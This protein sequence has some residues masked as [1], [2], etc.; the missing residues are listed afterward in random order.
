MLQ[1]FC[2]DHFFDLIAPVFSFFKS[3]VKDI[4]YNKM[5]GLLLMCVIVKS[6]CAYSDDNCFAM[7]NGLE[8]HIRFFFAE[9]PLKSQLSGLFE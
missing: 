5:Y 7:K 9:K 8:Q 3:C 1:I 4:T 6:V 2:N